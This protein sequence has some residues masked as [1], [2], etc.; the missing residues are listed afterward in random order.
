METLTD[1]PR[2]AAGE[3]G[4]RLLLPWQIEAE[5]PAW[6]HVVH[7]LQGETMGTTWSV[8]LVGPPSLQLGAIRRAIDGTFGEI[9]AQMSNWEPG[10]DLCRFNRA[11]AGHHQ[12]LP[13]AFATVVAAALAVARASG[14]A[15]DPSAGAL[16]NLWGFG[17]GLRHDAAGFTP[18]DAAQTR[19]ATCG[20]QRLGW[21]AASRT[22]LQPGNA[23]LDLSAIAKGYA[24]DR[25]AEVLD[26][27]G[28]QHHLVEIGGELR[29]TGLKPGAQPWWVDLEPPVRGC[30]LP[31]TRLALHGLAV[32]TSGDYR[33]CF[34]DAAGRRRSHTID[35][36]TG[37]PVAH[38]LAS[39]SVV[40][41][42]A[43][44]ADGWSTA[45]MVLGPEAGLA[46]A[47]EQNLAALLVLRRDDGGF[48]ELLT[49]ALQ[50][51]AQ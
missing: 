26:A 28:V 32:A 19:Q 12:V 4:L 18:P 25:V 51:M 29:G 1:R 44:M 38:G 7:S 39:V 3:E 10:S 6:G 37:Q 24:V 30:V 35:P 5:P 23:T 8:H 36:R 42:S 33:R 22:L 31:V 20:W 17:P 47:T 2:G 45:L 14:G 34:I 21:D 46:L 16:V 27:C 49:P 48:D 50:E 40:H 9:I 13:P 11:P 41:P 43:M 15:Y